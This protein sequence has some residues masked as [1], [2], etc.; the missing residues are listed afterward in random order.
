[1]TPEERVRAFALAMADWERWY[2]KQSRASRGTAWE[3]LQ[4]FKEQARDRLREIFAE[5]LTEKGRSEA[6]FG[7]KLRS[8]SASR[9][10]KYEQEIRRVEPGGKPNRV[11]VVTEG[12]MNTW[13][14]YTVTTAEGNEPLIDEL[15]ARVQV[16]G[17]SGAWSL[18]LY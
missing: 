15:R 18:R 13:F 14:R 5:H 11:Y 17:N 6:R 9:P 3:E 2:V 1:M 12:G 7:A 8:L 10:P 4:A 16:E